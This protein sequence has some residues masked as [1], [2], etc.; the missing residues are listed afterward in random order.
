MFTFNVVTDPTVS[1]GSVESGQLDTAMNV[2]TQDYPAIKNAGASLLVVDNPGVVTIFAANVSHAPLN[3]VAVRQAIQH[4]IN[5]NVIRSEVYSTEYDQVTGVLA[6]ST[7]DYADESAAVA[8]DPQKSK[9]LLQNDGWVPGN[10]GIRVKDGVKLKVTAAYVAATSA[11]AAE[12]Q[13]VQQDLKAVGIEFSATGLPSTQLTSAQAA[14][15]YGLFETN[16]T[17]TDPDILRNYFSTQFTN[18]LFLPA[19]SQLNKLLLQQAEAASAATRKSMVTEAQ[20]LLVGDAYVIPLNVQAQ[21]QAVA[22]DVHGIR[23]NDNAN[24]VFYDAWKS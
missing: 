5:R 12:M 14:G 16:G 13:I 24:L 15:T 10:D 17:L 19:T 18:R 21:I 4:A 3:D 2:A 23:F 8:Y 1:D 7:V 22:K 9:E 6:K 20:N 11:Y